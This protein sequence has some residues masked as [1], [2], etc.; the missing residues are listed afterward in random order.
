MYF[1]A[2]ASGADMVPGM[3]AVVCGAPCA[4]PSG[5]APLASCGARTAT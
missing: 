2:L 4:L 1:G 5:N 3:L